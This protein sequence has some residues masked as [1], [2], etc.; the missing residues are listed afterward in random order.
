MYIVAKDPADTRYCV[1]GIYFY[2]N[3][4]NH[5]RMVALFCGNL[6]QSTGKWG[7]LPSFYSK[8]TL[9]FP[10]KITY[11][12]VTEWGKVGALGNRVPDSPLFIPKRGERR[13]FLHGKTDG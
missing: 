2:V 12:L 4:N 11:T 13:R 10:A 7:F 1:G 5:L 6:P 8:K 3:Q 9:A